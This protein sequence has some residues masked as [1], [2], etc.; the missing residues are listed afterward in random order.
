MPISNNGS[1]TLEGTRLF[2]RNFSGR[3]TKVAPEGN[4]AFCTIIP[5]E[6]AD[7]LA[8]D[9]WNVK[10]LDVKD[11]EIEDGEAQLGEA[12][13]QVK[14]N[15]KFKPP[16]IFTINSLGKRVQITEETVG[17]LDWVDYSNVDLSIN[18]SPWDN[19]G[20]SGIAAYLRS[21]YITLDEDDLDRKYAEAPEE[22]A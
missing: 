21:L 16:N 5:D 8:R 19:N 2:W 7:V 1:I 18:P 4:R 20:K 12:Y 3:A 14:V 22:H 10:R 11:D 15:F 17:S 13:L 9:G 6:L